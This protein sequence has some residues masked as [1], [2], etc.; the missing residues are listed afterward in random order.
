MEPSILAAIFSVLGNF[1]ASLI[2]WK[3]NRMEDKI[4]EH[5]RRITVMEAKL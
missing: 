1:L 2:L 5:D 3:L 4:A